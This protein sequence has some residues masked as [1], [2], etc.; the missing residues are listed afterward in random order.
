MHFRSVDGP[1]NYQAAFG[2]AEEDNE[3]VG[4]WV[5]IA[6]L[7][8]GTTTQKLSVTLWLLRFVS[9]RTQKSSTDESVGLAEED[10]EDVGKWVTMR[11]GVCET[12]SIDVD[13]VG[14][15]VGVDE[16]VHDGV[17]EGVDEAVAEG[18]GEGVHEGVHEGVG[19]HV[20]ERVQ[21]DEHELVMFGLWLDRRPGA[22]SFSRRTQK[23]SGCVWL[24]LL[25]G[26]TQKLSV[27]LWLLRFEGNRTQK[28]STD[29]SVGLAEEDNEDVG[30]WV[31]MREGVCETVSIDVDGVGEGVG[32][33]EAVHDGVVEGVDEAV[34]EGVGEG[35]H[36]GVHEG[37]GEHVVER[38]QDD[39]HEL[40]MFGL[41]LDRRPGA[42]SFSRR[43]QKLSGCV[44]LLLLDG[45]TTQKLSVTLWLLRF[46]GNRTQKSST[47]ESV[48]L[49]EEDN[50]DVGKWVT[51][52]EGVCETVSIDVDGVGE[53]VGV[54][55]AVHDG[56]VE[57]VDEAV[58]E[59]V[60]EGVHEGVHEG[61][62]EHVVER[63]QDDEHE[64]VMFGL[65]LDRRPGALSFSR[66]TQKLSGCVWLLLLDGTTTQKLSV[67]LWLLRFVGNRTQKSSTDESVGLAEEDN[68]DVGKWVTMREGVCETVSIDVDG[69]GEG[70]GV[71]EAVHDG[72]VEGVD[73]AVA[74]G[75]GEGVHEG[76]HEGVGE[77]VVER[78][79]VS[80]CLGFG[81]R[82]PGHFRWCAV[83]GYMR[84]V[85][86]W[87]SVCR[88]TSTSSSC[89]GFG[90]IV[91]LVHF[92][93][94]DGPRN[95]QAAFGCCCWMGPQPRSSQSHCGC[96]DS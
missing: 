22:L 13:G 76:V 46:V 3:D 77:H 80:S 10:N 53:G 59:G 29:E 52:R 34:A 54:D 18:V 56:V 93:S 88:M 30:K 25:D 57:G 21:D 32:V 67:T 95:Y 42:L 68:E 33:D 43:T 6:V 8:D 23:L 90:W 72:V 69:V 49:A 14:E 7:L 84:E 51:M 9:N 81:D 16:A 11:E 5:T 91:V 2:L 1:R 45:T 44:W 70:V 71:D 20:V 48:G 87:W 65:W 82:R 36:E 12:V 78:V 47:D 26:T 24:L 74:E 79:Q 15:G 92:R 37:V 38:V 50:E 61:V 66:R 39:E 19:E 17:V 60:G 4:K 62:G 75:V 35:V 31:T 28:S 27:T 64:L 85:S 96:S 73:E 40:V 41:W 55:E 83:G 63:V 94:V 58:A 86:M 89:L